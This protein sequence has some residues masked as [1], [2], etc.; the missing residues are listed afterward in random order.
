MVVYQTPIQTVTSMLVNFVVC[1]LF[2]LFM[3]FWFRLYLHPSKTSPFIRHVVATLLGFYL[4]LF[5]FGWYALHFLVQSGL[6]YGVIIFTSVEHMHNSFR[7]VC[8]RYAFSELVDLP[9]YNENQCLPLSPYCTMLEDILHT[10]LLL[11][12]LTKGGFDEHSAVQSSD[13][14]PSV[15]AERAPPPNAPADVL[16]LLS[17]YCF[18]VTMGYLSLCHITREASEAYLVGLFEDTN[19]CAIHAKRVTIMPKDIQL[20]RRIRGERA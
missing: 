15:E 9:Y 3:A 6:A 13:E 7:D 17:L 12:D 4:A 20:A 18:V 11:K 19:L 2:A 5:C 16:N 14:G 10:I 8:T 1:Q